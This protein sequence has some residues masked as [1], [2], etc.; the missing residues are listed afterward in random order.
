MKRMVTTVAAAFF[1]CSLVACAGPQGATRPYLLAP[2]E[3]GFGVDT[4]YL[5]SNRAIGPCVSTPVSKIHRMGVF[6][7][8]RPIG[9]SVPSGTSF[10]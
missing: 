10:E 3:W 1:V 4:N 9:P 5:H 7:W 6:A 2:A 8:E